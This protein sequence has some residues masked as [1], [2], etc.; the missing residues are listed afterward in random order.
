MSA[1]HLLFAAVL[2]AYMLVAIPIEERDL[3]DLY[4]EQYEQYRR[5][6][7]ALVPR[8]RGRFAAA[9]RPVGAAD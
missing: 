2:T 5:Q 1:G 7:P 9:V 8:P 4:G 6:V 3:S